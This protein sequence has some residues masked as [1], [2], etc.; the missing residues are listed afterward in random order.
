MPVIVPVEGL[1]LRPAGR[2]GEMVYVSG[3]VPPEPFTGMNDAGDWL[4]VSIVAGMD[5]VAVTA[6]FTVS[7]KV[8][9]AVAWL[10]S[11]TVTV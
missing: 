6:G 4:T 7:V 10:L 3:A 8:V 9:C 11:V 5:V 1:M 2:D